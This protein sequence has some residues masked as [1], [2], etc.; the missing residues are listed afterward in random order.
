VLVMANDNVHVFDND[1]SGNATSNVM[2]VAYRLKFDDKRY[3]PLPR[4]IMVSGNRHG[5]AG[6]EPQLPGGEQLTAA[7]GGA[8]PAV[9][10]DGTGTMTVADS[11]VLNMNIAQ[12]AEMETAKPAPADLSKGQAFAA[13]AAVVL[14]ADMEARAK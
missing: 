9:L 4:Q 13:P 5:R 6:F 7:F 2:V 14:P 1:L 11:P 8:I 12:G 10:W 3:N